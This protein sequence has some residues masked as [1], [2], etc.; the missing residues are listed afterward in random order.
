MTFFQ[1][2]SRGLRHTTDQFGLVGWLWLANLLIA[3]PAGVLMIHA[4]DDAIGPSL[5]HENLRQGFDLDWY[6]EVEGSATG[7]MRTFRPSA[8]VGAG[9]L[10]DNLEGWLT[11]GLFTRQPLLLGLVGCFLLV[12]ILLQGGVVARIHDPLRPRG[13]SGLLAAGSEVFLPLLGLA[14]LSAPFYFLIYRLGR[15]S[16]ARVDELTRDT[17]RETT[18][19]IYAL[20]VTALVVFLLLVVRTVFDYARIA[21]VAEN[22]RF[23]PGAMLRGLGF[24]LS[25]PGKVAGLVLLAVVFTLLVLFL[26]TLVAPGVGTATILGLILGFAVQQLYLMARIAIRV[27]L[28]GSEVEL[29]K[30]HRVV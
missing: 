28:I 5:V 29:Y 18:V 30:G 1:A 19:L 13:L 27:T 9:P 21:V 10:L 7:L 23:P 24:V 8:V 20:V 14:I 12:W 6:G 17:T 11:G 25:R 4:L 16:M 22:R 26:Y 2:F 15:W 3:L